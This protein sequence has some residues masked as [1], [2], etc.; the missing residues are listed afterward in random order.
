MRKNK[1]SLPTIN[2]LDSFFNSIHNKKANSIFQ[3]SSVCLK[4]FLK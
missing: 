4:P 2:S 3:S 1:D